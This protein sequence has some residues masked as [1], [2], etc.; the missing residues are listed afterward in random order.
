[1]SDVPKIDDEWKSVGDPLNRH[2]QP[3]HQIGYDLGFDVLKL[4]SS[5]LSLISTNENLNKEVFHIIFTEILWDNFSKSAFFH[6]DNMFNI[7]L[8]QFFFSWKKNSR[9]FDRPTS[10]PKKNGSHSIFSLKRIDCRDCKF[11]LFKRKEFWEVI[12]FIKPFFWISA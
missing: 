4:I 10:K 12:N 1:M 5:T 2:E 8:Q 6:S 3:R 11:S 9:N 7:V